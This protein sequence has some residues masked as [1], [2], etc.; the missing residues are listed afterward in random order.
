MIK[1]KQVEEAIL[2]DTSHNELSPQLFSAYNGDMFER[3]IIAETA[4]KI[5]H[6]HEECRLLGC[7]AMWQL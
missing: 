1:R 6:T 3:Q 2:T 7:D 5:N 4:T